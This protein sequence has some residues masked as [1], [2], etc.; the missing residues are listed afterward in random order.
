MRALHGDGHSAAY[1]FSWD[2][3]CRPDIPAYAHTHAA[4]R[5]YLRADIRAYLWRDNAVS[6]Q[7]NDGHAGRGHAAG[8][9]I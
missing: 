3:Q 6:V 2:P 5:A 4:L 9:D 8:H 7:H 1:G